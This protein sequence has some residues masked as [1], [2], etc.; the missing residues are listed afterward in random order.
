MLRGRASLVGID[1]ADDRDT[2]VA[3]ID[4]YDWSFPNLRPSGQ[5]IGGLYGV[6][7]LPTTVILDRRG[8]I[9]EVLPGP[10]SAEDIARALGLPAQVSG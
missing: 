2:A 10:Q 5:S 3:F 8:R 7:G 4:R 6:V 9:A 1:W